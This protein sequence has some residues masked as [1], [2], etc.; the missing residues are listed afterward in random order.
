MRI[1][2]RLAAL[3]AALTLSACVGFIVPI[4]AKNT[5]TSSPT[6]DQQEKR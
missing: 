6:A 2:K 5:S 1:L 3:V 4:P